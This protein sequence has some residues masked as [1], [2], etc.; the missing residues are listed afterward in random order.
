MPDAIKPVTPG[1][2]TSG[3]EPHGLAITGVPHA[4]ASIIASPNG[5]GQSTVKS[6]ANAPPRNSAFSESFISPRNSTPGWKAAA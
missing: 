6:S 2:S 1:H 3:T 5:S 4:I